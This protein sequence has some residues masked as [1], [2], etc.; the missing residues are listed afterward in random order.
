MFDIQ[1]FLLGHGLPVKYIWAVY[2]GT[3]VMGIALMFRG[4]TTW[5]LLTA[6]IGAGGM[7]Y[8]AYAYIVPYHYVNEFLMHFGIPPYVLEFALAV[9]GGVLFSILVRVG[10]SGVSG[11]GAYYGLTH[12]GTILHLSMYTEIAIAIAVFGLFYWF[13]GK[14]SILMASLTG[15]MLL[16]IGMA[17]FTS[18]TIAFIPM[19]ILLPLGLYLQFYAHGGWHEKTEKRLQQIKNQYKLDKLKKKLTTI[20]ASHN[21]TQPSSNVSA[22]GVRRHGPQ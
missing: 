7:F 6:L 17:Y 11:Y 16:Y 5:K 1:Q 9:I 22:K 8:I 15:A 4:R 19:A 10:I 13:Y 12:Y 2:F 3:I 18:P 20:N 14:L 21:A